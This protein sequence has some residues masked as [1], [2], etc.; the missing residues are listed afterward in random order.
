V[1]KTR[2][3]VRH[4]QPI[5]HSLLELSDHPCLALKDRDVR[6]LG[7]KGAKAGGADSDLFCE[8]GLS[9][10][11]SVSPPPLARLAQDEELDRA[12]DNLSVV[13]LKR[14]AFFFAPPSNSARQAGLR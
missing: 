3:D 1:T 14:L 12:S 8:I 7:E 2:I 5:G 9:G 6:G 13:H 10:A 11:R 4:E